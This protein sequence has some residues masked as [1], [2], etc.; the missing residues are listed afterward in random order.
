MNTGEFREAESH[1]QTAVSLDPTSSITH[2]NMSQS[3]VKQGRFIE[4]LPYAKKAVELKSD[5]DLYFFQLGYI[6]EQLDHTDEAI[7]AY[8]NSLSLNAGYSDP[9]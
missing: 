4:A 2:Y 5:S 3:L 9:S 8:L 6:H 7:D 1:L